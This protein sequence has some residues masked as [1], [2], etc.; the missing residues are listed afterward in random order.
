MPP[1]DSSVPRRV[2]GHQLRDLRRQAGLTV[3]VAARLMEWSE[4]KLWRIETGQTT[5]RALDVQAMCAT[6]DAPLDLTRALARLAR[7]TRAHGWWRAYGQGI[8]D[9]F[10]VY[11]AL[12]EAACALTRYAPSLVPGLLRTEAYARAL[13]TSARPGSDDADRLVYDCLTRRVL[14][15]RA[16]APLTM[17][18]ALDEALLYR[19]VGGPAVMARQL[20]F[21]ADMAAQPNV[22]L[23]IVPHGAGHHPGLITGAFTLLDFQ[24]AKRDSDTETAIVYA[25][26]LTG[27]LYLDEPHEVQQY[28]DAH[29]AILGYAL[30]EAATVDLLFTVAKELDGVAACRPC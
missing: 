19:P 6:Y 1:A 22:S 5:L 15:T 10:G 2:L 7:H 12:E 13:I 3:K 17:T 8:P 14:L 9:D 30:D 24:P 28:R 23:R 11:E 20:R 26:G 18:L 21:L 29:A 27:E 16:R 4:P 25:A